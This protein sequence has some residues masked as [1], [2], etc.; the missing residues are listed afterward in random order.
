VQSKATEGRVGIG[1]KERG[2]VVKRGRI[3]RKWTPRGRHLWT[4][5]RSQ[6]KGATHHTPT[7]AE[8]WKGIGRLKRKNYWGGKGSKKISRV[9]R[10]KGGD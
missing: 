3:K 8:F 2:S 10:T 5:K 1:Q 4:K 9:L 7:Q 6:G